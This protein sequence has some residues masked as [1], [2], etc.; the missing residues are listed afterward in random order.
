[1]ASNNK[2][3]GAARRHGAPASL[4][5]EKKMPLAGFRA[6]R[7]LPWAYGLL[8]PVLMGVLLWVYEDET[9]FRVQELN[10]F[11]PNRLFYSELA[12]YPGGTLLWLSSLL[13]E[14]FYYPAAG[15]ALLAVCWSGI[16]FVMRSAFRLPASLSI[17]PAMA[18]AALLAGIVQMGY[19][20]FYNKLPGYHFAATVG[21]LLA[22]A[23]VWVFVRLY[24]RHTWAGIV[25]LAVWTAAGYPLLGAYALCGTLCMALLGLT[26]S[27][28]TAAVRLLT[29]VGG[30]LLA[31]GV[32]AAAWYV[33]SQT[34]ISEIYMAALPS[35]EV[36]GVV[37]PGYRRPFIVLLA[38]PV[39]CIAAARLTALRTKGWQ[40]V[41][42]HAVLLAAGVWAVN[43]IW[44][45]DVN[46]RKEL[47]ITR[48]I[49]NEDWEAVLRIYPKGDEEPTRMMVM[50]K[51][52]ALLRLGRAGDEMFNYREGGA[53]P[54][55][56]FPVNLSQ[57]GGKTLYY[58]YGQE[59]YCYRWCME[60]CVIYGW[61]TEYLK[62]MAR[63]S[64]AGGDLRVA[65]KYIDMLRHTLF[66][67]D[68]A[69]KYAQYADHPEKLSESSEF[70]PILRLLPDLNELTTDQSV[71]E[72]FLLKAFAYADSDDPLFQEQTLLAALQMKDIDIF[73][74]R[75]FKYATM[76]P[77]QHMPRH[78]QEAA[79]LYGH[80]ED[81]VDISHMPFDPEVKESHQRFMDLARQCQG[82]TEEEMARAFRPQFGHT[83]Y[84][85][86]F[87][88]NGLKTY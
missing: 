42:L 45:R 31:Q 27:S 16:Y 14:F 52:L 61:K 76:H 5:A 7:L 37:Y 84:Y 53:H 46:F 4:H 80:L 88:S 68:W 20:I 1:M 54:N 34:S 9:L 2:Q 3:A 66:H 67:K 36:F 57:A 81:K 23:A 10:L 74:P 22:M 60:D 69:E 12:Q 6:D 64:L 83:F 75:F 24:E 65:R 70:G 82:M 26:D 8:L 15:A 49:E 18:P 41:V 28:K 44:Y 48:A 13:T 21:F 17:L 35:F 72:I 30:M 58:H 62:Y 25:W 86:Y 63:T 11:L 40:T 50:S 73:W 87:L 56:P 19:F 47:R 79:C 71:I 85:F 32:P 51:N 78:Y 55:A 33:Y 29:G 77:G 43:G 38:V 39:L 59:N